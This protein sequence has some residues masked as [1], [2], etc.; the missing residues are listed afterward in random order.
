MQNNSLPVRHAVNQQRKPTGCVGLVHRGSDMNNL[1]IRNVSGE[2]LQRIKSDVERRG[3]T[4]QELLIDLLN[5]TYGDPPV[6]V[7]WLKATRNGELCLAGD[8][9]ATCVECG[10]DLDHVWI[11]VLSNGTLHMPVC[12]GCATSQ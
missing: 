4:Q 3:V 12:S 1:L 2:T 10:Q 5:K 7:A 6:V 8:E 11:G 9:P